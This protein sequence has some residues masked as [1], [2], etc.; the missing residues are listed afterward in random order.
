M[1]EKLRIALKTYS[2]VQQVVSLIQN[3][4]KTEY[5]QTHYIKHFHMKLQVYERKL[6]RSEQF[7][8]REDKL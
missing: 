8:L 4:G 1:K 5:N 3:Q 7:L 6:I 2:S